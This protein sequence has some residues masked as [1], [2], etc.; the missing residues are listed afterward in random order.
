MMMTRVALQA[1][2]HMPSAPA[3]APYRE[4][5]QSQQTHQ[6][7]P[8]AHQ[9]QDTFSSSNMQRALVRL[10]LPGVAGINECAGMLKSMIPRHNRS[11]EACI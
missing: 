7:P 1:Q 11:V 6:P 4:A 9:P 2:V 10:I 8:Q 3:P 5:Q